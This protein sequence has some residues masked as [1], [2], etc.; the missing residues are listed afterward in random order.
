[1]RDFETWWQ[2]RSKG[3]V[4]TYTMACLVL[5]LWGGIEIGRALYRVSH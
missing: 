1:M 5:I 3:E 4:A 2:D